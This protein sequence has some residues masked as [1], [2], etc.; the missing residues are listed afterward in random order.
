MRDGVRAR[1]A[2]VLGL[3]ADRGVEATAAADRASRRTRRCSAELPE[4]RVGLVHGRLKPAEKA[5]VMA[6]FVAGRDPAAGR[7]DRDRSRRGRAQRFADGDRARRALRPRAAAPAA[8]PRR[9]RR[10]SR[11]SA[12]CCS[13]NPLPRRR[14]QRLKHHLREHRRLRDRARTISSCAARAS[15]SARAKAARRCCASPTSTPTPSCSSRRSEA[16]SEC[17]SEH[18]AA[19]ERTSSAGWARVRIS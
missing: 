5:A 11:A 18:P 1:A 19:A 7:D 9:P 3:P 14:A 8:R 2:G 4:L 13:Q 15:C 6:A 12:S 17:S 16:A 10:A